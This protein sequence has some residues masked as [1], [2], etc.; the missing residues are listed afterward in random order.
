MK[1]ALIFD[2]IKE[3]R[4]MVHESADGYGFFADVIEIIWIERDGKMN[5]LD[6]LIDELGGILCCV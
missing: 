6:E 1:K 5:K 2:I 3:Y 4:G